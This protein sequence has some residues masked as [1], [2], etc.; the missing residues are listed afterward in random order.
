MRLL[1]ASDSLSRF[2]VEL[3]DVGKKFGPIKIHVS[4]VNKLMCED[5]S[6]FFFPHELA[7]EIKNSLKRFRPV[8]K[9]PLVDEAEMKKFKER[10]ALC[11]KKIKNT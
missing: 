11:Q 2:I 6:G 7:R 8:D 4:D 9:K 5:A 10:I 1:S 3:G